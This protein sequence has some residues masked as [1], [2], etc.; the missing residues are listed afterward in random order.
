MSQ[1]YQLIKNFDE[2][3]CA[4]WMERIGDIAFHDHFLR[5]FQGA[6]IFR[7]AEISREQAVA[8]ER[9]VARRQRRVL[10]ETIYALQQA[11][12]DAR[13][14]AIALEQDS[15]AANYNAFLL[16]LAERREQITAELSYAQRLKNGLYGFW[17]AL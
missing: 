17:N 15:I 6:I 2:N 13:E 16:K 11:E 5:A 4:T 9:Y 12:L 14:R 7:L 3:D 1:L 10:E 8:L